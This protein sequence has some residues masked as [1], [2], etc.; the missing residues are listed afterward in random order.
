MSVRLLWVAVL[1]SSLA[2]AAAC[3][4]SSPDSHAT[5]TITLATPAERRT[6]VR[7]GHGPFRCD[8]RALDRADLTPEQW[9][10]VLRVAVDKNA[11]A[12]LGEYQP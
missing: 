5:P 1:A 2:G 10:S 3:S 12:V 11:P 8:A 4:R 9:V 7:R 6:G